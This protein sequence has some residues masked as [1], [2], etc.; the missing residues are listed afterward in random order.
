MKERPILFSGSMVAALLAGTKTQTRRIVKLPHDNP[1][2]KWEPT[3]FGGSDGGRTRDGKTVPLERVIWHTR[4]GDSLCCPYG[5]PGDR[6][7]VR[8]T[9][10]IVPR[11]AYAH[12]EGVQQAIRHDDPLDHDAA[13]FREGW[14]RS[15]SGFS[16]RPSIHMPRW[17]SRITLEV[18]DVRVER[19]QD[20]GEADALAEGIQRYSGPLRW[21]RYIDA[22]TGD[23]KHNTPRD[24]FRSLW[25]SI[26]GSSSWDANPWI[27][28]IEFRRLPA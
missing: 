11:T 2:G 7:W 8:E 24:A 18:T 27:W 15:Q 14:T 16:W 10:A 4:T 17:A 23:A 21:V 3:T 26:N 22:L 28:A 9:H 6:L 20:I 25:E 1:L 13:I 5:A 12:S 19:L